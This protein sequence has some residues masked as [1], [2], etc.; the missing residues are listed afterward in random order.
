MT[1]KPFHIVDDGFVILRSKGVYRQ[2]KLYE[3]DDV[4]YAGLGSGFIKLH[5]KNG[6]SA[7]SVSWLEVSH[8]FEQIGICDLKLSDRAKA[9]AKRSAA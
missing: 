6:T 7:P 3:R 9:K 8:Q 5:P 4:L 1:G 2:A